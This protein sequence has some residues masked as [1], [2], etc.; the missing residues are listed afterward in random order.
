M[1]ANHEGKG[2][3]VLRPKKSKILVS[4]S[5]AFPLQTGVQ[6]ISAGVVIGMASF[7][8]DCL[9]KP[10]D[11]DTTAA[12]CLGRKAPKSMW[13]IHFPLCLGQ[14]ASLYQMAPR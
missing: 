3:E 12:G 5:R 13:G 2:G 6:Q 1:Y 4:L 10:P 7:P 8:Y 11:T 14:N 9:L